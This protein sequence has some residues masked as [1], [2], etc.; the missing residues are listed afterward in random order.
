MQ[1]RFR[2]ISR[3]L[4]RSVTYIT[5]YNIGTSALPD[6]YALSPPACGPQA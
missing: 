5:S 4:D 3:V 1:S 6:M 2:Q